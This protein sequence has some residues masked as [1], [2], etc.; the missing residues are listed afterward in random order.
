M[1]LEKPVSVSEGRLDRSVCV[2]C[3]C[4]IMRYSDTVDR[5]P[6]QVRLRQITVVKGACVGRLPV[7][8]SSVSALDVPGGGPLFV[9]F[10]AC[11]PHCSP[12]TPAAKSLKRRQIAAIS[13]SL[14]KCSFGM[15]H[16]P[17]TT[18]KPSCSHRPENETANVRQVGNAARLHICHRAGTE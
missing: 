11:P 8:A 9:I 4:R 5:R 10:G 15:G 3:T 17:G 1:N 13:R 18:L 7:S 16:A 12:H 14:T 2:Q 6:A